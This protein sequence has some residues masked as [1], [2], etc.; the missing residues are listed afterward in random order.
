MVEF[1]FARKCL[2]SA[3]RCVLPAPHD[4]E[5]ETWTNGNWS[6]A[7]WLQPSPTGIFELSKLPVDRE[8]FVPSHP[9]YETMRSE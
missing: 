3:Q 1:G 8:C 9:Y 2:F 7:M 5:I 6:I 4:N